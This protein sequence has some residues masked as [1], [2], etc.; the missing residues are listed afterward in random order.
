MTGRSE[1]E[2]PVQCPRQKEGTLCEAKQ[3]GKKVES[4][5]LAKRGFHGKPKQKSGIT[6]TLAVT[7]QETFTSNKPRPNGWTNAKRP[8]QTDLLS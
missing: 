3:M 7:D 8:K 6:T 5:G 4:A 2:N 1:S